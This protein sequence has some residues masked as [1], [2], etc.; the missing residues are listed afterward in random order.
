MWVGEEEE[1]RGTMV[2]E[3][4]QNCTQ[5]FKKRVRKGETV[6]SIQVIQ[7]C[8]SFTLLQL[9]LHCVACKWNDPVN[10][11]EQQNQQHNNSR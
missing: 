8:F 1:E 5:D 10:S 2:R 4:N 3:T 6:K 7:M 11:L 9:G